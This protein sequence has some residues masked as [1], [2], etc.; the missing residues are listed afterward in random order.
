MT[1]NNQQREVVADALPEVRRSRGASKHNQ[2]GFI[3]VPS[4][5]ELAGCFI[6]VAV[7]FILLGIGLAVLLPKVWAWF[8]PILLGWL[9]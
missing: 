8:K 1:S 9:A 3:R 4:S 5:G 7:F 2:R 6:V